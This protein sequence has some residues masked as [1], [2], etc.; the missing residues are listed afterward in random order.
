M[1]FQ[2]GKIHGWR[3]DKGLERDSARFAGRV[4]GELSLTT[5]VAD[6]QFFT[7]NFVDHAPV[8]TVT[9][10]GEQTTRPG[11]P[12]VFSVNATDKIQLLL[13]ELR[14]EDDLFDKMD[15][16]YDYTMDRFSAL[17]KYEVTA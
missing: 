2:L 3:P 12:M 8:L 7:L 11:Q 4:V 6:H 10:T 16:L 17:A 9:P 13:Q 14:E 5:P 1:L 15:V